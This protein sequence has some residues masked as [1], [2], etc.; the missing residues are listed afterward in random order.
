MRIHS[1]QK[2]AGEGR[3]YTSR[4]GGNDPDVWPVGQ[5]DVCEGSGN[6]PCEICGGSEATHE[7]S[8][9][10]QVFLVC[11]LCWEEDE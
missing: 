5:C 11:R 3:I 1:C 8:G 6:Q 4:Y 9:G 2:C 7:I 10:R